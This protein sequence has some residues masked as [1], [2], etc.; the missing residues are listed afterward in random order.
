M[1]PKR[2]EKANKVVPKPKPTVK[3]NVDILP[4]LLDVLEELEFKE[5]IKNFIKMGV[6]ETRLM[7]KLAN[8]D[9]QMMQYDW[10]NFTDEKLRKLKE[11]I[12]FL[13]EMA[14]VPDIPENPELDIRKKMHYGR[15]YLKNGVTSF[16]FQTASFG[17][18]PP[19]GY[20]HM[21]L[22]KTLY[23]CASSYENWD[24]HSKT[25]V[26]YHQRMVVVKRGICP[27]VEKAITAFRHNASGIII[28]N[29]EDKIESPS[30]GIGI[31][32]NITE[33]MIVPLK[34]FSVLS[35]ANA[36]GPS[37]ISSVQFHQQ[38][39]ANNYPSIAIVP[40]KCHTGGKCL[41]VTTEE[42]KYSTE[43]L[44]GKLRI[45]NKVTKETKAFEF[46]TSNYGCDLP[47][48]YDIPLEYASP[49]D[50]CHILSS[51]NSSFADASNVVM[52]NEI[53]M[54]GEAAHPIPPSSG[55]TDAFSS[56]GPGNSLSK[57]LIAHRG[58]CRF[59]VK[60]LHAQQYFHAR[61]LI[62]I[63]TEDNPLQRLGGH[64]PEIGSIGIPAIHVT[65]E[66][67]DFLSSL[68]EQ[69]SVENI[70][71]D[72]I[73]SF[74]SHGF[75]NWLEIAYTEWSENDSDRLLQLQGLL[76]KFHEKESHDIVAWLNRRIQEIDYSRRKSTDAA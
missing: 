23:E 63:D 7:L 47:V 29:T 17:G 18:D 26:N 12:K 10:P 8:M 61:L 65:K 35:V 48:D 71:V 54:T 75:D 40:L 55:S 16:E 4:P 1:H 24:Q 33:A 44:S 70:A 25:V 76:A 45:K 3:L 46:L 72:M 60:T 43:V 9:F 32:P 39:S 27:F 67:G 38:L 19:I 68:S 42:E 50:L 57:I 41:P 2:N 6:T 74:T 69:V 28:I 51:S 5:Y 59:D 14:T 36:S 11:K 58:S 22:S 20:L 62:V 66:T 64:F 13:L 37:L 53:Q 49:I 30:S 56:S 21:D 73:P 34:S 52:A 31:Y 15:I